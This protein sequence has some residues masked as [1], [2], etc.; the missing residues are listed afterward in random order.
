MLAGFVPWPDQDIARWKAAG[1]RPGHRVADIVEACAARVPDKVAVIEG[2]RRLSYAALVDQVNRL[3]AA[4]LRMGL[5]PQDRVV[6]QLPNSIEFVVTFLALTRMGAVP[7]MAL[8][9]H[10]HSEIRHFVEAAG[11]VA[12]LCLLYTS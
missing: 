10:R 1:Y 9:A 7:V 4:L 2:E 3:A 12:Y 6:M 11:A 8:R 5:K